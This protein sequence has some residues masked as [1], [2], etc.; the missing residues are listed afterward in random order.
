MQRFGLPIALVLALSTAARAQPAPAAAPSPPVSN[1]AALVDRAVGKLVTPASPGAVVIVMRHGQVIARRAYGLASVELGV[2]MRIDHRFRIA[3]I[4]KQLTA[5]AILQLADAGAIELDAP[6]ARY[7]KDTPPAWAKVTVAQVLS[8]TSGIPSMFDVPKPTADAIAAAPSYDAFRKL[9][10]KLPMASKPGAKHTYNNWGY[11]LLAQLIEQHTGTPYCAYVAQ[12]L[13]A[14]LGMT[15]TTCADLHVIV[16]GL[17]TG[18]GRDVNH[19]NILPDPFPLGGLLAPAG[20]WI[21]TADDLAR[22]AVALHG[23]KLLSPAAYQRMIAPT[24]LAGAGGK[25]VPY[26]FGTRTRTDDGRFIVAANGDVPG[27]H[28]EIA[29]DRACDCIAIGLYNFQ[30]Y[31]FGSPYRFL[32][33]R[34][35][36]IARGQPL[37]DL[38]P[39][40]MTD[41]ARARLVGA[42]TSKGTSH[43]VIQLDGGVLYSK[44]DGDPGRDELV[45]LGNDVFAFGEDDDSRIAFLSENG[46]VTGLRFWMDGASPDDFS[47]TQQR[48]AK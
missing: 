20:G 11:V 7:L 6:L 44:E 17:V 14:P 41:E 48:V 13:L 4:S 24:A 42:Y 39:A 33:R 5:V 34:M 45:P 31:N 40:P 1:D 8:H 25:T 19:R 32:S 2:P 29:Y 10:D 46:T 21:S 28:S 36:A 15:Q 43:R 30:L 27:F 9:L 38:A 3:S 18:Y 22:W 47:Y 16:P 12:K 35:L 26:G 23:G 37:P